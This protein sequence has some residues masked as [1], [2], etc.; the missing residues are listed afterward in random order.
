[1]ICLKSKPELTLKQQMFCRE[2]II[3][4]NGTQAA[5]RAGYSKHTA[6]TISCE[7]LKKPYIQ[8]YIK[9]L[10][11]QI[12]DKLDLSAETLLKD[13]IEIRDK[14]NGKKKVKI[15]VGEDDKELY[16]FN[17]KGALT[18][19]EQLGKHIG[20]FEKDNKQKSEQTTII[21]QRAE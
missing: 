3:D 17:P 12:T 21:I 9:E 11:K 7:N 2:Y 14:C 10:T 4:F 19:C 6:F 15:T 1:M 8:A 13:I 16:T 20:L 18:A 5:I